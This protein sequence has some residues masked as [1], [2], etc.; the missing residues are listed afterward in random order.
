[1]KRF[2]CIW[3]KKILMAHKV[4]GRTKAERV[5]AQSKEEAERRESKLV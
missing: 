2:V 3:R 1:M 5:G 4:A